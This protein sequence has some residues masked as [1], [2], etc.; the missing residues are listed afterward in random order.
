MNQGSLSHFAVST[1]APAP[2][3]HWSAFCPYRSILPFLNFH[4]SGII[5][6]R[7]FCFWLLSLSIIILRFTIDLCVS[8]LHLLFIAELYSI[9]W[10]YHSLLLYSPVDGHLGC[11]QFLA[12]INKARH[13]CFYILYVFRFVYHFSWKK[14]MAFSSFGG[15]EK[16]EGREGGRKPPAK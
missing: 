14:H 5:Q 4:V 2:G 10:M 8:V 6:Y 7:L 13:L 1:L 9:E 16:K 11:F 12:V 15:G 3:N